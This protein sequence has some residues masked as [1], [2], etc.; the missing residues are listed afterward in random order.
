MKSVV[1]NPALAWPRQMLEYGAQVL[2]RTEDL[3]EQLPQ[4]PSSEPVD[5]PF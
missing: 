1:D 4:L 2:E 3:L 5:A